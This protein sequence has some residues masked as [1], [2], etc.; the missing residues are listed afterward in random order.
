MADHDALESRWQRVWP[1]LALTALLLAPLAELAAGDLPTIIGKVVAVADGNTLTILD[2]HNVQHKIRLA[3]IDAPER[4]QAF[5]T[6]AR[7]ALADKAFGRF[8]GVEL[9]GVDRYG[10]EIGRITAG[11]HDVNMELVREGFAWRYVQYDKAGEF[12]D[13][14]K[15]AWRTSGDCGPIRIR[16]RLGNSG[17]RNARDAC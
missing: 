5:G 14:E 8:V 11:K 2:Y 16:S 3:G 7:E 6:K 13:V 4:K 12:T 15:D 17:E 9:S 10:R 1:A